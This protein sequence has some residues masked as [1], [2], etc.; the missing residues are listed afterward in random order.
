MAAEGSGPSEAR[1]QSRD[2]MC[3]DQ[4]QPHRGSV[5]E[6]GGL[7]MSRTGPHKD[8]KAYCVEGVSVTVFH[9]Q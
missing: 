9:T 1:T 2:I 7:K 4:A 6:S 3:I 5:E 8:S